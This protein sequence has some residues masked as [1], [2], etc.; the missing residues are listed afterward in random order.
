MSHFGV[1][2][3]AAT[4]HLNPMMSLGRELQEGGHTVTFYQLLDMEK[5]VRG[6]G[7]PFV[8]FASDLYPLGSV[9]KLHR[10]LG[11]LS[12][13]AALEFTVDWIRNRTNACMMEVPA[14]ARKANVDAFLV[15]QVGM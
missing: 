4:G 8:P 5:A 14:L 13:K 9:P 11:E 12:G 1:I 6:G 15:D 10:A 7:F 2:C 3:P